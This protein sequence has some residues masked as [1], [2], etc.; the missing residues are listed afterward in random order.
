MTT[1]DLLGLHHVTAITSSAPKIFQLM[2]EVLGL[3]LIKKTVNQDDVSAYHL[4]FTDD[5]GT[6]GTDIT[7]FDF[8]G[9]GPGRYGK[10]S[11]SRIGFRVPNDV[12]LTYWAQRLADYHITTDP[13][14]TQFGAAVL[15]FY[16]FDQQRYQLISDEHQPD[17]PGGTPYRH[18]PVPEDVAI[19][20]LGTPIITVSQA[21]TLGHVLTKVMGFSQIATAD[22]QTLYELNHGGHA[23]QV[24]VEKSR[25]L[26]DGIQGAGTV[27]HLAFRTPDAEQ[28]R[29]WIKRVQQFGL[30]D[31]GFVERFYFQSEYFRAAPG[32]LFEIA[33]DGPGF[34]VDETY[35]EAGVHLELPP[36]L[37][38]QRAEIEANLVPF[39]SGEATSDD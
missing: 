1:T 18:S 24:I 34:L 6:A 29:E 11:I 16:D 14:T 2:T 36:F 17:L 10:N 5:M 7:F 8:P 39:N 27:H 23:A 12:A 26:P 9:I 21:E 30:H 32:I 38:S 33:T 19:R 35:D 25:V 4:Y 3:H 37:E 22:H 15:P 28:L 31:S 20:G 13:I